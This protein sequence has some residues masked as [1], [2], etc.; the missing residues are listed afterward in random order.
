MYEWSMG[1]SR[2]ITDLRVAMLENAQ[3]LDLYLRTFACEP[4]HFE[5]ELQESLIWAVAWNDE[6]LGGFEEPSIE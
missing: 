5:N 1:V 4:I 2:K 6:T 3:L